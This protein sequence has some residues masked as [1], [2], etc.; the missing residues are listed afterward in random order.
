ME[1]E[2][3]ERKILQRIWSVARLHNNFLFSPFEKVQTHTEIHS[4]LRYA[5]LLIATTL[6]STETRGRARLWRFGEN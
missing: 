6:A 5:F 3:V 2:G 1:E 4:H